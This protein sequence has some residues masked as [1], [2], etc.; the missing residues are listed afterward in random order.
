LHPFSKHNKNLTQEK[1]E[2]IP[3]N[4]SQQHQGLD[5]YLAKAFKTTQQ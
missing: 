1:N 3:T 2:T 4:T 5:Y